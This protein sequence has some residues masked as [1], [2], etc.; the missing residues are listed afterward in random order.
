MGLSARL[1]KRTPSNARGPG[2]A[3]IFLL[4]DEPL[5]RALLCRLLASAGHD[6]LDADD[7]AT[8][9][10]LVTLF[11]ADIVIAD[12]MLLGQD[13]LAAICDMRRSFP[14]V[15]LII[16]SG[17]DP[18]ELGERLHRSGLRRAVWLLPKPFSPDEL[19]D[20]LETVPAG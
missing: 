2:V 17:G 7:P 18:A 9:C 13:S 16:M 5:V 8:L 15:P 11:E 20:L 14:E 6:V 4:E 10:N 12:I 19:L 3:R 1:T